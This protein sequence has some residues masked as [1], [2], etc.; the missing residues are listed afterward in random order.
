[1]KIS[2]DLS[3]YPLKADYKPAIID[4]I[5]KLRE[6]NEVGVETNGFS[7]QLFGEY[8]IVMK[9]IQDEFKPI[10][11]GQD[12]VVMIMKLVNDDLAGEVKF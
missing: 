12:K 3:M 7:T 8:D 2:I 1:M 4:F 9:L 10:F 5:K 11:A 6:H